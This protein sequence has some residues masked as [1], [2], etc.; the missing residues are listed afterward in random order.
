MFALFI[1]Y[2]HT[3]NTLHNGKKTNK[4]YE[5]DQFKKNVA[6]FQWQLAVLK[7]NRAFEKSRKVLGGLEASWR[8]LKG[9][10]RF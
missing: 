1:K 9:L 6:G 3:T 4:N 7:F 2:T 10:E 5:S 8:V